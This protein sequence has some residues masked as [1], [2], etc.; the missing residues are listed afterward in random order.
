MTTVLTGGTIWDGTGAAMMSDAVLV[1]EE[2]RITEVGSKAT[3][4]IPPDAEVID[5]RG[6][7]ILPGLIDAHNHLGLAAD[8]DILD[9]IHESDSR[10]TMRA[11]RRAWTHLRSG[12]TTI[13]LCGE[14]GLMDVEWRD[15]FERGLLPGPRLVISGWALT[16]PHGHMAHEF[17]RIVEGPEDMRQ[18]VRTNLRHGV[19]FIKLL[20][21]G[22]RATRWTQPR[23][24]YF[25][26]E[27]I[28]IAID[29][30]HRAGR[31]VTAHCHGG[32]GLLWALDAGID[33]LE[34][35][36]NVT[37]DEIARIAAAGIPVVVTLGVYFDAH[38]PPPEALDNIHPRYQ[39]SF[40]GIGKAYRAGVPIVVGADTRHGPNNLVF[41]LL[42]LRKCGLSNEDLLLAATR[43][44]AEVCG[45]H[46]EIGT[47]ETGKLADVVIVDGNPLD[48]VEAL[49]NV[50]LVLKG[51]QRVELPEIAPETPKRLATAGP[52]Y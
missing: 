11:M 7:F 18:A 27:E 5:V 31:T 39:P 33:C 12:I 50:K 6:S 42:C 29:E 45:L 25:S 44:A 1:I 15:A 23:T 37:D 30:A 34:H 26:K 9:Q 19:D 17:S 35:A 49:R 48:D 21:T 4:P 20:I 41:E 8:I 40:E 2:D 13:R 10:V 38:D 24:T 16:A 14:R 32:D 47:L 3:V 22:S 52:I 28:E 46:E 51:G 43:R 36:S